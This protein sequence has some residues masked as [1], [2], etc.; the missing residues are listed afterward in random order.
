MEV[1]GREKLLAKIRT[2]CFWTFPKKMNC[3]SGHRL[4]RWLA[5]PS[6]KVWWVKVLVSDEC[7]EFKIFSTLCIDQFC[8]NARH[9]RSQNAADKLQHGL[10][11]PISVLFICRLGPHCFL[12]SFCLP[13]LS[14]FLR[15]GVH[16]TDPFQSIAVLHFEYSNKNAPLL[17]LARGARHRSAFAGS[18]HSALRRTGLCKNSSAKRPV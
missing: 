17:F 5:F 16:C 15:E 7:K 1:E 14:H 13:Q 6:H 9:C 10:C 4:Q 8:G 2:L 11:V 18:G 12:R 3:T